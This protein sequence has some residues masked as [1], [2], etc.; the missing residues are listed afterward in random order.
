MLDTK[1]IA[2]RVWERQFSPDR[3]DVSSMSFE[4]FC[5]R[6]LVIQN[7]AGDLIPLVLND[8]Q[9]DLHRNL[10]GRD[11]LVKPRQKGATTYIQALHQYNLALGGARISTLC[12]D[13]DLTQDIR[14]M[15]DRF[16]DN[17]PDAVRPRRKYANA[18]L[19]TYPDVNS[20]ARIAT[21]G[22][23]AGEGSTG[24]RKGRGGTNTHVHGTE[25]AYWPDAEGVM[26]SMM[27][28]GNPDIILESTA[29]GAQGW[30]YD[31]CM[32]ALDGTGPWTLHFYP[33]F[34]DD[35]YSVPL[36]PGEHLDY[37]N[38]EQ[39][40]IDEHGL[41]PEQIKWRRLKIEEIPLK[42]AQEYPESVHE[43]F[44]HSG[45]SV[46][47]DVT[48]CLTAP[49]QAQPQEGHRYVA[50]VDWGQTDDY[51]AISI[52]DTTDNV[53]VFVDHFNR[54]DWDLMQWRIVNEC[55]YWNVETVQPE[56]NSIG[57]VN[58]RYMREKFETEGYD[59]N[60]R[61]VTTDNRKKAR[62]VS[63]FY[64]AI[65]SEG[66]RLLDKPYATAELRA[67]VQKQ[68]EYGAYKYEGAGN[69]HDDT[70]IARLLANDAALK[71]VA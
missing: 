56:M 28:A 48:H 30:F 15:A 49:P 19:T 67:F 22:G 47:G 18:K 24:K 10:T 57:S 63:N 25:V 8:M 68:T 11:L 6:Y 59:I 71:V 3:V 12:H 14:E 27:Q 53:E 40:L 21:V 69:A 62:W 37:T 60:V 55:M 29:N 61:P 9:R 2:S 70:V 4:D 52:I 39:K 43:A 38:D 35:E 16:Y 65:H 7:K 1:S 58:V 46:F 32:D 17:M 64:Q 36:E 23:H 20:R 66:L 5:A 33:W 34:F 50:G 54:M 51:T 42:F 44:I 41:T 26:S 31:R 13:D 45:R